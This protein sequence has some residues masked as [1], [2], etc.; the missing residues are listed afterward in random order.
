MGSRDGHLGPDRDSWEE[1]DMGKRLSSI[2][3]QLSERQKWALTGVGGWLGAWAVSKLCDLA[4]AQLGWGVLSAVGQL[5]ATYLLNWPVATFLIG[6]V[7]V[8][9]GP[10]A[11]ANVR[12]HRKELPGLILSL[13]FIG[14]VTFGTWTMLSTIYHWVADAPRTYSPPPYA[15]K[16][17]DGSIRIFTAKTPSQLLSPF[18][19]DTKIMAAKTISAERGKWIA[20][21]A[22]I[23]DISSDFNDESPDVLI[24]GTAEHGASLLFRRNWVAK[25]INLPKGTRIFA[26]CTIKDA[27][28]FLLTLENCEL[29]PP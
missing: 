22:P 1:S 24:G 26:V 8:A 25:T 18:D 5:I 13:V 17:A 6:G 14:I 27:V 9:F 3:A 15:M 2:W 11:W 4:S 21:T 16:N 20:I 19:Q 10:N 29:A 12:E 23:F 7:V 28:K